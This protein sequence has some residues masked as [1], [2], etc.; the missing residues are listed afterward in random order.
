[1]RHDRRV[2][3]RRAATDE[4]ATGEAALLDALPGDNHVHSQWSWDTHVGDMERTCARG[5]VL[6]LPSIAFTEH[7]DFSAWTIGPDDHVPDSFLPLVLGTTLTPPLL[8]LDGYLA[9]LER[10]RQ[11]FPTLRILSGV[12]MSE[13]HWY[14]DK[15]DDLLARGGLQRRLASVHTAR[16]ADGTLSEV[17]ARYA[18]LEPYDVIRAYLGDVVA[19]VEGYADFQVLAH[20]DYPLR[21]WPAGSA[22]FDPLELEDDYRHVLRTLARA[23]KALELNTRLPLHPQIL[24]WWRQEGGRALSFASDAHEPDA[25][26][27]GFREAR[28]VALAA[29]FRPGSDPVDLW[30]RD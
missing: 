28:R 25:L 21:Y 11:L 4:G 3:D 30:V 14:A 16:N 12:E 19:L 29:G 13:P 7:A 20:I 10:C 6:G 8:D 18:V 2:T 15:F 9:C 22:P 17:S 5:V 26:A 1:V 24:R 27:R 23:D